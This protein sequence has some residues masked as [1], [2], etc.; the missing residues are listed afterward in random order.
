MDVRAL[1]AFLRENEAL[2]QEA[3][4]Q[5]VH[6]LDEATKHLQIL[7]PELGDEELIES[8]AAELARLDPP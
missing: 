6:V 3:T 1:L 5:C 7:D 4:R 2:V 8:V